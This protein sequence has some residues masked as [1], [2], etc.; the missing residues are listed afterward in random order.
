MATS[1]SHAASRAC[2]RPK[3]VRQASPLSLIRTLVCVQ[4]PTSDVTA[5]EDT[6]YYHYVP[7]VGP[8]IRYVSNWGQPCDL[9][10]LTREECF[11]YEGTED[12]VPHQVAGVITTIS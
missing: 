9:R 3:F 4:R 1:T 10:M 7:R 11:G 8:Y 2:R 12:Q 5:R 6:N